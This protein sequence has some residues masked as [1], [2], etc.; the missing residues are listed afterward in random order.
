[1]SYQGSTAVFSPSSPLAYNTVFTAKVS[2]GVKDAAGNSMANDYEWSFMTGASPDATPP[3]VIDIQP[4][5]RKT[6]ISPST[7][8]SVM[9]SEPVDPSTITEATIKVSTVAGDVPGTVWY[10][11]AIAA[12][13]FIPDIGLSPGKD[14]FVAV[15]PGVK[16]LAKN[17]MTDAFVSSFKTGTTYDTTPPSVLPASV[18]PP[19]GDTTATVNAPVTVTFSEPMN[20]LTVTPSNFIVSEGSNTITGDITY[21]GTTI[22]FTL[23]APFNYSTTYTVTIPNAVTDL[24]GN[25]MPAD[26]TWSFTTEQEAPDIVQPHVLSTFPGAAQN[27]PVYKHVGA[28]FIEN[29]LSSSISPSTFSFVDQY[30][31]GVAGQITSNGA[32]VMFTPAQPLAYD[33]EYTATIAPGATD[34]AGNPLV[35]NSP[36]GYTWSFKTEAVATFTITATAGT[37]GSISPSGSVSVN[38]GADQAFAIT[39]NSHYHIADVMVD[40]SSVGQVA[41]H[42]FN[43]VSADHTISASFAIDT[44]TVTPSVSGANGSISPATPQTVNYNGTASFTVTPNTG[45]H[46]VMGGTCGGALVGNT[47]TTDP[48]TANC[49]VTASF[50]INTYTVTP[51]VPG[52]N[53]TIA[54]ATSQTVNHNGTATFTLTPV[55]G[56]NI[57]T[58]VGGTCGGTLNGNVYTTNPVTANCTVT[59]S[60]AANI[61]AL[62][63][64]KSGTGAG[65]V[66]ANTGTLVWNGN[67]GTASYPYGTSVTLTASAN[68]SSIFSGWTGCDSVNGSQCTVNINTAM[69]VSATFA[70]KTFTITASAGANGSI[71]PS[72]TVTVNYG[73]NQTFTFTPNT[74]YYISAV[75][76]DSTP[77]GL[78]NSYTFYNV[79]QNH[80]IAVSFALGSYTITASAGIGGTIASGGTIVSSGASQD[81]LVSHGGSRQFTFVPNTGYRITDVQV[82]GS[83][84]GI[85]TSHTF[86][87]VTADHTISASFGVKPTATVTLGSLSQTYDGTPKPATATTI[88]AGLLVD[89]TYNGSPVAPTN[90]GTYNVVGTVNDINYQGSATGTLVI[91]KATATVTLGGLSQTYDGAPKPATATTSPA[92]LLVDFTY[93]GSPVAPT[94][95]GTYNVVGTVNDINYQ[96]S[97]TGPL[98][99]SKAAASVTPATASKTY[100]TA[101]PPLTGTLSGFVASDN[102]TAT[103]SRTAG[104]TVAGSPYTI[105]ATL[106]PAGVLGNY[107]ITYNTANFTITQA[108]QAPL[109]V[110]ATPSTVAYGSTSALSTTGGSGTGAV[111]YS[112]GGSTGCSVTG[113]TLS[114]TNAGGT[115]SVT[116]TKAAD[117]NYTAV[118]SAPLAV[119]LTKANPNVTTWPTASAITYGQTLADVTLT[120]GVATQPGT[121]AFTTPST[122]PPV[123]TTSYEVTFMP[124]DTTNYNSATANV[125]VTVNKVTPTV[126]WADPAPITY[127]VAL[128]ATQL[129]A[130]ASVP[131]IFAYTPASGTV[132][133]AGTHTLSV[134]FTPTDTTNYNSATASV[135]INVAALPITVTAD[136]KTKVYGDADPALTYQI[137]SGSLVGSD[138]LSG[139]LTRVAGENVGGYAILQGSL[140]NSNYQITFIGADLTI[141]VRPITVTADAKAKVY[142]DADPALTYS[143]TSG[144]L[145]G[146][147]TLTGSLTRAAGENV[148]TYAILQGT[149]ANSNYQI[150]F[151]GAD[152]TIT[153][154]PLT[155]AA[156]AKT[157]VYGDADPVLTYQ[158]TSGSL[159]G[160]DTLTGSLTRAAGENVDTYAILQGTLDAGSNYQITYAGASLTIT[161]RL[162]AITADAKTKVYGD[163]DPALTYSITSGSLI[164]GDTLTGALTRVA[165]EN[166][167]AYAILQGTLDAGINYVILF[168]GANMTVTPAATTTT[169]SA[170]AVTLGGDGI[171]TVTVS[172]TAGTPT[173][174]VSL[175]V[176]G[177]GAV[178][179]PLSNGSAIFTIVSPDEGDHSLS[180]LYTA[181]GNF[182]ASSGVGTLTVAP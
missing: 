17:A 130:T 134:T 103:Y 120:G 147:D 135:Q 131:G 62:T 137:T 96:G 54:P 89:F 111:T 91:S 65:T 121:F 74:G 43:N 38:Y 155:V 40:G 58:P 33:T 31:I 41:S 114:V 94:N 22:I 148:D 117:A 26:Y 14:Y 16:D 153:V 28:L 124:T 154:R 51:S 142:G 150:A 173:G 171:V 116:A 85:I 68:T 67:T 149:L 132:L 39:P 110:V 49:T 175:S 23:A 76:V 158:I 108:A 95:A 122:V 66:T 133:N 48:V 126:T 139:A 35:S 181:Q 119:T 79:T 84:Q 72:G 80:T 104:E 63:V 129:N 61:Y 100:G 32:M 10:N 1:M 156:D 20:V 92:G 21:L 60:F 9:F 182:D 77:V 4:S 81:F 177:G 78:P 176:D 144:S 18:F 11:G 165:G 90:A 125:Q 98:T 166:V 106:S 36:A 102:V 59:A 115:C 118:T 180:A 170:P 169:I 143:I 152:L 168:S 3:R 6:N 88:P 82:D 127:G 123:G 15:T 99:I 87:N 178:M 109:T 30:G 167:G 64:T 172:S 71:N 56:Y 8:I 50:A 44:F 105:S 75:T 141:T 113:S 5:N 174:D 69:S 29:I 37:G 25:S 179:Q 161:A 83:S 45:Y 145:V 47:Y 57:V 52:G 86:T 55:T 112:A 42:T 136:A 12:A 13:T 159:V 146:G 27:V 46:A 160:G 53:G 24:A 7:V 151:I 2:A 19:S 157:K 101:D 73:A 162:L 93:N 140:A 138:S 70:I 164:N 163:V 97:A 128:G 107:T 34:L